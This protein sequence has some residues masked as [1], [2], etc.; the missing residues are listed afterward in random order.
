[1]C[2]A[3]SKRDPVQGPD[4][5]EKRGRPK[6][7]RE[8]KPEPGDGGGD[9]EHHHVIDHHH[10]H[11]RGLFAVRQAEFYRRFGSARVCVNRD[12]SSVPELH[13]GE[14]KPLSTPGY[15]VFFW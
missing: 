10:H 6:G 3:Q 12:A 13:Q 14:T 7:G 15:F 11:H 1:M 8:E 5:G 4:Q 2:A 9:V